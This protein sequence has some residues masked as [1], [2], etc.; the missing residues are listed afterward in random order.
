MSATAPTPEDDRTAVIAGAT[1]TAG[2][3]YVNELVS[4]GYRVQGIVR[5]GSQ[6]APIADAGAT[7]VVADLRDEEDAR[8]ALSAAGVVF[9]AL[10]GRGE[11]AAADERVITQNVIDAARAASVDHVVYTSVHAADEET[12]VPH[13]EVKGEL[14]AYLEAAGLTYTVLRPATYMG[15]LSAPWLRS[16]IDED[17]V[18]ASP[19]RDDVPIS[20]LDTANLAELG[21]LAI[22]TDTLRSRTLSIGGPRSVTYQDLLPLYEG[23]TG[24]AVTYRNVPLEQVEAQMGADVAA[25]AR[26][27]NENGFAVENDPLLDHL[28]LRLTDVEAFLTAT[29]TDIPVES[30]GGV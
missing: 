24:T 17:G 18:L 13:F 20:Y 30:D 29:W 10:L 12:G 2:R 21:R 4:A 23:L 1:G 26:Y 25:M 5:P 3:A 28:D 7:P 15:A 14:E 19:I 8:D 22:E 11:D 27:F 6:S 16:G 9:I